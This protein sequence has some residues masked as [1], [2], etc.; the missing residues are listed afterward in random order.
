MQS[1]QGVSESYEIQSAQTFVTNCILALLGLITGCLSARLLGVEGRGE[2]AAIQSWPILL[3]SFSMLG[4]QDAVIFHGGKNKN[5]LGSL[6]ITTTVFILIIGLIIGVLGWYYM[7]Y[8]LGAQRPYLITAA[9]CYILFIVVFALG[10]V[11]ATILRTEQRVLAWNALRLPSPVAW[12]CVL[13][14]AW[15]FHLSGADKIAYLYLCVSIALAIFL[16]F[17]GIRLLRE[18]IALSL[19]LLPQLLKYG[20]QVFFSNLP[21]FLNL[22]LDQLLMVSLLP[23][24]TLG[25]YVVAVAW[26]GTLNPLSSALSAVLF[27]KVAA[28]HDAKE[29]QLVVIRAMKLAIYTG[30]I[31]LVVISVA[32]PWA[33]PILFGAQFKDA[34]KPAWIL[35]I[36]SFFLNING[37]LEEGLKGM[38]WPKWVVVGELLGLFITL[39]LLTL[40]LIPL[41]AMGAAITSLIAYI[42]MN[43]VL[44][45]F[46]IKIGNL[47]V[48]H[49]LRFLIGTSK[50]LQR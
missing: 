17:Y 6:I 32:T 27:P 12:L 9:R 26:A 18:P 31:L 24:K 42:L 49:I 34:I 5:I 3:A 10:G 29:Q 13:I 23:A 14:G 11:P 38:G 2:L 16:F 43:V 36:A 4:L 46:F 15:I 20:L 30:F 40:L 47:R 39:G 28:L 7:P 22:K 8:L 44:M 35:L 1:L 50:D 21:Q 45:T 41:G 37:I 19:G 48:R 25:V 33:V